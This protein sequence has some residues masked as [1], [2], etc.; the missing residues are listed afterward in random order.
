MNSG[1]PKLQKI[2]FAVTIVGL[3]FA[4]YGSLAN[5]EDT[6]AAGYRM[7]IANVIGLCCILSG[8]V[9]VVR[10]RRPD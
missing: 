2:G 5:Q 6:V 8:M 4:L 7:L 9:M 3:A 10:G 1:L